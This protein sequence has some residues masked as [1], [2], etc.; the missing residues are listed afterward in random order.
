MSPVQFWEVAPKLNNVMD[1]LVIDDFYDDPNNVR[2]I[3]LSYDYTLTAPKHWKYNT[4]KVLWPGHI[5]ESLYKERNIDIK[6]SKLLGKPYKSTVDSGF[7]RMNVKND[8]TSYIAHTDGM[9]V[10]DKINYS[11]I[12][13]LTPNIEN[14][15]GTVFYKHKPTNKIKIENLADANNISNDYKKDVWEVDN[16]I[17]F[18]YNRLVLLNQALFHGYGTMFGSTKEDCRLTQIFSFIQ[19]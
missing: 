11:G 1:V 16:I 18:K 9:P 3:A 14:T 10:Q 8:S 5:T 2:N 12:I 7:F 4:E 19:V 17:E 15:V 13:Y 6:I